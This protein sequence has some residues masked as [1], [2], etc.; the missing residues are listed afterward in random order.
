MKE[1]LRPFVLEVLGTDSFRGRSYWN[2]ERVVQDYQ[3][4]LDGKSA[5]SPEIWRI[6]CTELWLRKFFDQRP[7]ATG[8][9][10]ANPAA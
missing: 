7:V 6:F 1:N 2:A 9:L 5:Y 4:F 10:P 8:S 3:A